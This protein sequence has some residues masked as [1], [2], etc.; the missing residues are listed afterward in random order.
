MHTTPVADMQGSFEGSPRTAG[1][2]DREAGAKNKKRQPEVDNFAGE[3]GV[4]I[5]RQALP[6][7]AF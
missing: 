4:L 1:G 7:N 6:Q 3:G 2:Y 5:S